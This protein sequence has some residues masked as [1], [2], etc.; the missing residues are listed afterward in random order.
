M[1]FSQVTLL[2]ISLSIRNL[3]YA[4]QGRD[5]YVPTQANCTADVRVRQADEV[6]RHG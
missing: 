6:C 1:L 2:L 3:A 4:Q 5:P